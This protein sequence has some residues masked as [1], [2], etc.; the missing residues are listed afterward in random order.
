MCTSLI[1]IGR[2]N[3][4]RLLFYLIKSVKLLVGILAGGGGFRILPRNFRK[5][6][7]IK[8]F[9]GGIKVVFIKIFGDGS[10]RGR[11]YFD[12]IKFFKTDF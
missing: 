1:F 10:K 12:F 8:N 7:S 6:K 2:Q 9:Q 4:L 11:V 3:P 5:G